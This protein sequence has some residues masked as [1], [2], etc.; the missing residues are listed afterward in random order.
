MPGRLRPDFWKNRRVPFPCG[1]GA[2]PQRTKHRPLLTQCRSHAGEVLSAR[3]PGRCRYGCAARFSAGGVGDFVRIGG[4]ECCSAS[5]R[6]FG[7]W[8]PNTRLRRPM[9]NSV[10]LPNVQP[11]RRIVKRS[12]LEPDVS[13]GLLELC[14]G[15]KSCRYNERFL[16]RQGPNYRK[17]CN[18]E[19][20]ND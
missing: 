5:S 4:I 8:Q 3:R 9:L 2:G 11:W 7:A 10:P 16:V 19:F 18:F 14:R 17:K 13:P 12:F 20:P 1:R 15:G 6:M